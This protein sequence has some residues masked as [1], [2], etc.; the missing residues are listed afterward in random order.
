MGQ[1]IQVLV[2]EDEWCMRQVGLNLIY[3]CNS[4]VRVFVTSLFLHGCGDFTEILFV[5]FDKSVDGLKMKLD[6]LGGAAF[7]VYRNRTAKLYNIM[8]LIIYFRKNTISDSS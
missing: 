2:L 3:R 1:S 7:D 5:Y 8:F 4:F 6:L